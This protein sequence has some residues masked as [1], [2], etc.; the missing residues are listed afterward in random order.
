MRGCFRHGLLVE[1]DGRVAGIARLG[2][3][4]LEER[5]IGGESRHRQPV[6]V[7]D[8]AVRMPEREQ[9]GDIFRRADVHVGELDRKAVPVVDCRQMRAF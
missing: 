9:F 2:D 6:V 5:R 8:A 7:H 1:R 4:M 3:A